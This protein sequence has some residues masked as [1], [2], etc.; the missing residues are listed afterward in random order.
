MHGRNT[1]PTRCRV[2]QNTLYSISSVFVE[3]NGVSF[4]RDP[5]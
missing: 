2:N 3:E 5:A 1:D 4:V